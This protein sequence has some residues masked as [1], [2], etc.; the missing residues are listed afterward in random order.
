MPIKITTSKNHLGN[1]DKPFFVRTESTGRVEF[2]ELV[3]IMASGRTTITAPDIAGTLMLLKEELARLVAD[4]RYVKTPFGSFHL[5]ACGSFEDEDQAFTPGQG[6]CKHGVRLHYRPGSE[7]QDEVT[8]QAQ[9]IRT[10]HFEKY[11]PVIRS[12]DSVK[13]SAATKP[14]DY[15]RVNGLRLQFDES[16]QNQGVFFINGSEHRS[17]EYAYQDKRTVVAQVP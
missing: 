17:T 15:V 16:D 1:S 14:G 10:E 12:V 8:K 4:G 5:T 11:N 9:F 2:E 3:R 13:A 6:D 7:F